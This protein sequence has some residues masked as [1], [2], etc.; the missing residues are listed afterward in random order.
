MGGEWER[1]EGGEW[2]HKH[3]YTSF[4]CLQTKMTVTCLHVQHEDTPHNVDN[5]TNSQR[6]PTGLAY[7]H[8]PNQRQQQDRLEYAL[9]MLHKPQATSNGFNVQ[10]QWRWNRNMIGG[11]R[12]RLQSSR[13]STRSVH[14]QRSKIGGAKTLLAPPPG[15][16]ALAQHSLSFTGRTDYVGLAHSSQ[17]CT[18][19]STS[20]HSQ[21][22]WQGMQLIIQ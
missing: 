21:C 2:I 4:S 6:P 9:H 10:H 13:L 12:E 7:K 20:K 19:S 14:V 5:Q 16:A 3:D 11:W 17:T 8:K 18:H 1:R 22:K 15:S